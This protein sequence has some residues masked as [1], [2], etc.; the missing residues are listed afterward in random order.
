M[1]LPY[2]ISFAICEPTRQSPSPKANL[3][4]NLHFTVAYIG[5][6]HKEKGVDLIPEIARIV[7]DKNKNIKF[8]IF[9]DG[10]ERQNLEL[11]S[12]NLKLENSIRFFG[13]QNNL[14]NI[15]SSI[16]ILLLP[17]QEESFPQV[18]LDTMAFGIPVVAT[19][20]GGVFELVENNK[21]GI[22]IKNRTPETFANAILSI[23]EDNHRY[24]YFSE[25]SKTKATDFSVEKMINNVDAIYEIATS[26]PSCFR[27]KAGGLSQ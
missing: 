18:A 19:D 12:K 17:S 26:P 3:L 22:L 24:Q 5:R 4:G 14:E 20:V 7:M 11:R 16:D 2:P 1:V 27:K 15:Y 25:N 9:G 23:V 13:W 10:P 8:S 21:T 6:L